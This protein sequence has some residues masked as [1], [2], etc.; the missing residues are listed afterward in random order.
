MDQVSIGVIGFGAI[1]QRSVVPSIIQNKSFFLKAIATKSKI[2]EAKVV[3]SNA[4]I[5]V[6]KSYTALLSDKDIDCVYISLP[7][8]VH[9]E[10]I[11]KALKKG[12]H[13]LC[14]K[15][16][17]TRPIEASVIRDLASGRGLAVIE[18]FQFRQHPQLK[19][20]REI[21]QAEILGKIT[22]VRSSFCFPPFESKK[23]IRYQ[24]HL[25]GGAL[26][27]AGVY[28]LKVLGEIGI[29]QVDI[30]SA[31]LCRNSDGVD[32]H[33]AVMAVGN[34]DMIAQLYFG[35]DDCYQCNLEILGTDRKLTASR[36]YTAPS[37]FDVK[38]Y[39]HDTKGNESVVTVA[40]ENHFYNMLDYFRQCMDDPASRASE[41]ESNI[42]QANL[43]DKVL[44]KTEE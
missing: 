8:A 34:G 27:D 30:L 26:L 24:S 38:I 32:I 31:V 13:V 22:L 37:D 40:A 10:W 21:L 43:I 2:S 23:N 11:C 6:Y 20:I 7:T 3:A 33:G 12:K 18:N 14:E 17:V 44:Q 29:D 19:R 42:V 36:I 41:L 5:E 15:S 1:A 25:G 39:I 4:N 28:T 9:Y 16:L 35:F